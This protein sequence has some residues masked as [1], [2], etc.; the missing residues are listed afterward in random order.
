M[1]D[2]QSIL[3]HVPAVMLVVVR[4]GGLMVYGPVIGSSLIPMQVKALLAVLLGLCAYPVIGDSVGGPGSLP[5]NLWMLGPLM[6]MEALVGMLIGYL[7]SLP[8][9]A[10]ESSG[11]IMGQQMGL[12]FSHL[13]NPTTEDDSDA[14]GEML[15][16]MAMGVFVLIGGHESM[17]ISIYDSF[18]QVPTGTIGSEQNVVSLATGVLTSAFEFSLRVSA[19]MLAVITL[20]T[21]SLGFLART[22]PQ[23]NIL[24]LGF[25][26]RILLGLMLLAS[27]LYVTRD[28]LVDEVSSAQGALVQWMNGVL[29]TSL[30]GGG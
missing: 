10:I 16:F 23:L 21:I 9:I 19:P 27:S 14:V 22:V 3:A 26:L 13:I 12:G 5:L 4:I 15:F 6:V 24:N 20:E 28:V 17:L 8:L 18:R 11:M 1:L 30:E 2:L 29:E 7:A 25:P